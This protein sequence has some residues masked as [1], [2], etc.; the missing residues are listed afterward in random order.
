VIRH[1]AP[2]DAAA[3]CAIY[4][5]YVLDTVIS[6]EEAPV[7]VEEM[8]Q[9]IV[10]I[11][12]SLPW[13]VWED[14]GEVV[15]YAYAAPWR[16]RAA[17]RHSSESTVYIAASHT[18]RGIGSALYAALIGE[19]RARGVHCVVGAIALPN[20]ASVALHEKAG[21][22]KLGELRDLGYKLGRWIDV[23]YWQLM[24]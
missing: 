1:C 9:R 12:A 18:R 3:I 15:G 20:A 13:L 7:V 8:A 11:T 14:A 5:P 6:F 10:S 24:L 17:Y 2:A 21:F 4:N 22:V 19:L 16:E 23:G